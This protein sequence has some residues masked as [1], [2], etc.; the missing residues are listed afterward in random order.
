[1]AFPGTNQ[2]HVSGNGISG[3]GLGILVGSPG[4]ARVM[5][6]HIDAPGGSENKGIHIG[7]QQ[8]WVGGRAYCT[9]N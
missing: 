5:G 6:N 7:N 2:T 8:G 9:A 4:I 1:M 3:Y